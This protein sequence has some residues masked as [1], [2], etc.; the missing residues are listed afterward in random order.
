M[1]ASYEK[2]FYGWC[3]EQAEMLRKRDISNLDFENIIEEI[4]SMGGAERRALKSF[5]SNLYCHLLKIKFQKDYE[6][7][8][9]WIETINNCR[10]SIH[11]L[12]EDSPS[13]KYSIDDSYTI[14]MARG[15]IKAIEETKLPEKTIPMLP[16]FTLDEVL[17]KD[18]LPNSV[19]DG[20]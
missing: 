19:V 10:S 17:D 6:D 11:D 12:V 1:S 9:S 5:L 14:A 16:Q 15:R 7:K 18:W 13:L 3:V 4:E 8:N 20:K 2:D